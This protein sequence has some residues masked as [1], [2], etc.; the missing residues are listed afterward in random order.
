M[1]NR[2]PGSR[3]KDGV[4]HEAGA[5]QEHILAL[6]AAQGAVRL[7]VTRG[8]GCDGEQAAGA[9][10]AHEDG[11]AENI[12][13][14]RCAG[15]GP[16]HNGLSRFEFLGELRQPLGD[17]AVKSLGGGGNLVQSGEKELQEAVGRE[18][19]RRAWSEGAWRRRT[20]CTAPLWSGPCPSGARSACGR[21]VS[22]ACTRVWM[23]PRAPSSRVG[24]RRRGS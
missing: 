6:L 18:C 8:H 7:D 9:G 5:G 12:D 20:A 10:G 4:D 16:P 24:Q 11:I 21:T 23:P 22:P 1:H 3:V 13:A 2:Q 15:Y 17:A 19:E 14:G